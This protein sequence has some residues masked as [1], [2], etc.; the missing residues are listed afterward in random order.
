MRITK[1]II[2]VAGWGTRMLPITKS[3]EKSM[4]PVGMRPVIDY[5]VQDVVRAGVEDIFFV[6]GE[7]STQ[8]QSYYRSNIQLDDYLR[9]K[10]KLE[11]LDKVAPLTGVNV[12]F[13]TQPSTGGYGTSVPVGL[14]D[15]FIG[16]DESALVIM[17][18]QFF[19]TEGGYSNA[20]ALI[21]QMNDAGLR[22]A[23]YG[24]PV[25]DEEIPKHGIIEKDHND[26]FVRILEKPAPEDAPSNLNNSSFYIF[27]KEIFSLA[28]T[29]PANPARGEYEVTDAINTY[30]A[31]GEHILVAEI[32][33]EYM[34][35]GS[36]EGWLRA[37]NRIAENGAVIIQNKT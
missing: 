17:G 15:E 16:E 20:A 29:L 2:P 6:V 8:I 19:W 10:G 21:Q 36:P 14:C 24:N 35:C 32:K 18:D 23:L 37:N 26:H 7:Q 28:R 27:P 1:A 12:H 11:L 9:K 13:I 22:A 25:P 34:E 5:V 3:I 33:G 4:L 31:S 30:V